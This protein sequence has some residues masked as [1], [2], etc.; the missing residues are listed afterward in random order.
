MD[1]FFILHILHRLNIKL[2]NLMK[3]GLF[4]QMSCFLNDMVMKIFANILMNKFF[5]LTQLFGIAES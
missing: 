2:K 4:S 1:F 3:P 5:S